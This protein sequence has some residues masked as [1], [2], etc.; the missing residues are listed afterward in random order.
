[1]SWRMIRDS[2]HKHAL[3][4]LPSIEAGCEFGRRAI[5]GVSALP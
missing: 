1:M 3:H 4:R 5:I 2:A